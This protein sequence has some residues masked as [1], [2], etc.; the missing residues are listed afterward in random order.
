[1]LE[2]TGPSLTSPVAR[3]AADSQVRVPGILPSTLREAGA[4]DRPSLTAAPPRPPG[5]HVDTP[6]LHPYFLCPADQS[7]PWIGER[8]CEAAVPAPGQQAPSCR[9]KRA[10]LV[11]PP[12]PFFGHYTAHILP[13]RPVSRTSS[14]CTQSGCK[15]QTRS[16][17]SAC[18]IAGS[19]SVRSRRRPASGHPARS[20]SSAAG[21]AIRS[22][23]KAGLPP[24]AR[25]EQPEAERTQAGEQAVDPPFRPAASPRPNPPARTRFRSFPFAEDR[26]PWRELP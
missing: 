5:H 2:R 14:P 24:S 21:H 12:T 4:S 13:H 19:A 9:W 3:E 16:T 20:S 7:G 11:P 6:E 1:M 10:R 18:R 26:A 22:G 25:G 17:R 15:M 8:S 23:G